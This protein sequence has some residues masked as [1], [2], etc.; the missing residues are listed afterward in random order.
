MLIL[1]GGLMRNRYKKLTIVKSNTLDS[2]SPLNL[3]ETLKKQSISLK[4]L[5]VGLIADKIP[6]KENLISF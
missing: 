1:L 5:A 6:S 3:V 2:L 4:A